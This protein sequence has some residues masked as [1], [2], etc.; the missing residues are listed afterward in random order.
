MGNLP[1]N[2]DVKSRVEKLYYPL[3]KS[4]NNNIVLN[5]LKTMLEYK[6]S[7]RI[8]IQDALKND[9]FIPGIFADPDKVSTTGPLNDVKKNQNLN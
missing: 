3:S 4:I 6:P 7:K 1:I 5:F 8:R 2:D 9:F